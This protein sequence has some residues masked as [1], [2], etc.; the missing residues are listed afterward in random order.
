MHKFIHLL[1]LRN[2]QFFVTLKIKLIERMHTLKEIK[3]IN[4]DGN[5]ISTLLVLIDAYWAL[6]E[7]IFI[8]NL[9]IISFYEITK[10]LF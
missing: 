5:D 2:K 4:E 1:K 10:L 6:S 8:T 9:N 3:R 7:Y